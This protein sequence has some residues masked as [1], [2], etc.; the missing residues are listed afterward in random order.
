MLPLFLVFTR[1]PKREVS[2]KTLGFEN[3]GSAAWGEGAPWGCFHHPG[4]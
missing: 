3:C 1:L 2:P 4:K